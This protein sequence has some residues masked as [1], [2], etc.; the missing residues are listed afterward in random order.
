M[1]QLTSL[2]AQF[3]ALE[4]TRQ[5]GHVAGL[6]I[7][8]PTTAPAGTLTAEDLKQL[9]TSR[10][11]QLPPL[12]WR[13]EQV[14]FGLDYPYWVDDGD[15]DLDF[16]VRELALPA[17]GSDR[18]L[19]EQVARIVSRPLD[20]ARPLWEL[21]V[22][23]GLT[24]G[25]TAVLTKIHHAVIDGIS[26]AELTGLLLDLTPDAPTPAPAAAVAS[27]TKGQ[28]P[29]QWEM[30]S[31]GLL[32]LPR[33]P[34]RALR[35]VPTAVP[36]LE[37][38]QLAAVPGVARLGR[39]AGR[40]EGLLRGDGNRV[41]RPTMRAPKTSFSG[42]L[43]AHRRYAF[44]QLELDRVKAVKNAHGCTVNDVVVSVCAGAVRR[45]LVA[46]DELPAE[47]LIAQIP[48]SVRTSNQGGTYGN[49]ILL[50]GAPLFT[51]E[52][53]PIH[54]LQRTHEALRVMK[55]RHRALPAELLADVNH[56]IP[57]AIFSRAARLTFSLATSAAGRPNW[58]LVVS[59]VPGP[60]VPLYCAGARLVANY[61]VSVITDGMGLNITAMSYLDQLDIGI[62]ADREQM[63][64]LWCLIEYLDESLAELAES[65]G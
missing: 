18:Q 46:H 31:R 3:L 6:A 42:R 33:Y 48:V 61:P 36:N 9:I 37:E 44:G 27:T 39:L 7:Y 64:D 16:H 21:Y 34:L 45:W 32:G 11:H 2:D 49:R 62:V 19:A 60:R 20:R 29:G 10:L 56:F 8:D 26:G 58:N 14:P 12:Q 22:I 43:S 50:L 40:A 57:P 25:H 28:R 23:S 1:R 63:A 53:D 15:F 41:I 55:E 47:P 52:P 35:A 4:S 17:P 13:L 30:L 59:N 24:S 38:S 54:R 65:S 51:N 5:T